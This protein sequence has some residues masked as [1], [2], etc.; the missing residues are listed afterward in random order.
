MV[1]IG[2]LSLFM[3]CTNPFVRLKAART[4]PLSET[5]ARSSLSNENSPETNERCRRFQ[6]NEILIHISC[7]ESADFYYFLTVFHRYNYTC[8]E[9]TFI[10]K[11]K[12]ILW[13]ILLSLKATNQKPN[14]YCFWGSNLTHSFCNLAKLDEGASTLTLSWRQFLDSW[15]WDLWPRLHDQSE[16]C[17]DFLDAEILISHL[18]YKLSPF[19]LPS[20]S[21]E[22]VWFS[23]EAKSLTN[24]L[25][26]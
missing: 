9:L 23:K 7:T 22:K 1:S 20:W 19:S 2:F 4:S 3:F 21:E 18:E 6:K 17:D 26:L 10:N 11:T 13:Q 5:R 24:I 15:V 25:F 12:V 8:L 14:N 16:I